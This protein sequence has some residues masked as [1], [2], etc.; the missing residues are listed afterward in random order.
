MKTLDA[1]LGNHQ[2]NV[3][4]YKEA[5]TTAFNTMGSSVK[6]MIPPVNTLDKSLKGLAKNPAMLVI[7]ALVGVIAGIAKG[8]KSS[9]ENMNKLT[10]AF[11]GFKAIGEGVTRVLQTIAGVVGDLI[12]RAVDWLD[13]MGLLP[14]AFK[15][16]RE[17]TQ[18]QIQLLKQE[19]A[20][21]VK[22]AEVERDVAELRAKAADE[23]TYSFQ[24]RINFLEKAKQLEIDNL[25]VEKGI[26]QAKYEILAAQNKQDTETLNQLEEMKAALIRIDAQ[27]ADTSRN[28]TKQVSNLRKQ[29]VA[30]KK[31]ETQTILNLQKELLE[32]EYNLEKQG[33]ERQLE[34]SKEIAK[35][36]YEIE[37]TNIEAK[38]KNKRMREQA[39]KLALQKYHAEVEKLE[40]E[41]QENLFQISLQKQ[42]DIYDTQI[43]LETDNLEKLKKQREKAVKEYE[44]I[45]KRGAESG[46]TQENFKLELAQ[47][48][49]SI[50]GFDTAIIQ[51]RS[52]VDEKLREELA[53][54]EKAFSKSNYEYY[55]NYY[56]NL[57][58]RAREELDN[59]KKLRDEVVTKQQPGENEEAYNKRKLKTEEEYQKAL[60]NVRKQYVNIYLEW[61]SN[62]WDKEFENIRLEEKVKEVVSYANNIPHNIFDY[63]LG[64]NPDSMKKREAEF[65]LLEQQTKSY[66]DNINTLARQLW[67]EEEGDKPFNMDEAFFL[68]PED[69][70]SE[71]ISRLENLRDAE[72]E[73][74]QQRYDN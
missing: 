71:Y 53:F 59:F 23:E 28:Y 4:N 65:S 25:N 49:E 69:V 54:V 61:Y 39:E 32:Q 10:T 47:I 29:A 14:K 44:T 15:E 36:D 30:S 16:Q 70:Q 20:Q 68:L 55:Q 24:E 37:K 64:T 45:Q 51:E 21:I 73:I 72:Q 19:R 62:T 27:I 74:L 6:G 42:N 26:L 41:H 52:K 66:F 7:T 3:G 43:A 57:L 8:F 31:E 18:K 63:F 34:L 12:N 38:F 56:N 50:R 1:G 5:F 11:S 35:K 40:R 48:L 46:Q 2:R 17:Q 22:N 13:K 60:L 9:E 67:E 33:S 58:D